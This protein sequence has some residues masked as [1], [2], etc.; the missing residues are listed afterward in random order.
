MLGSEFLE[1]L[2]YHI[3]YSMD[4]GLLTVLL[5]IVTIEIIKIRRQLEDITGAKKD[6]TGKCKSDL[7]IFHKTD[8]ENE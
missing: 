8:I 3:I 7:K 5:L 1:L 6:K 4:T 2:Y